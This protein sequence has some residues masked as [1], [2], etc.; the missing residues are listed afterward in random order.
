[1]AVAVA[2]GSVIGAGALGASSRP[3][4]DVM[5]HVL[6]GRAETVVAV[7]A[8]IS[9]TNTSLLALTAGSRIT[10]GMAARGALPA[11]LARVAVS[12]QAPAVAIAVVAAGAVA[13]ATIGDLRL[14]ASVTD[15]AVYVVFLAVNATVVLLRYR[16]PAAPRPFRSPWSIGRLPIL[17]VL[18]VAAT[19]VMLPRLESTSLLIGLGLVATGAFAH[20]LGARRRR[21]RLA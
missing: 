7:I 2:A 1:M 6:G 12:T 21:R 15:F 9:T 14:V 5:A 8:L 4:A 20:L 19:L 17:P 18:G 13:F 11:P 16:R 10:Y 3:L